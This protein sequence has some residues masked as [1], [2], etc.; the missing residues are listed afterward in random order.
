VQTDVGRFNRG[1]Q[2]EGSLYIKNIVMIS[3]NAMNTP[4]IQ[5]VVE[6]D[7]EISLGLLIPSA[8]TP[9]TS[10]CNRRSDV[11]GGCEVYVSLEGII[12]NMNILMWVPSFPWSWLL[13]GGPVVVSPARFVACIGPN[14]INNSVMNEDVDTGRKSNI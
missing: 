10:S 4:W 3:D 14:G 12:E 11:P 5:G 8:A 9:P 2:G 7:R 6:V 13:W 1:L